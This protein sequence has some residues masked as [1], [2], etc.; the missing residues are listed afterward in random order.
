MYKGGYLVILSLLLFAA[1]Q[2][3]P[4]KDNQAK[5]KPSKSALP[6]IAINK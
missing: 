3:K 1:C 2:K 6:A 5:S 4:G